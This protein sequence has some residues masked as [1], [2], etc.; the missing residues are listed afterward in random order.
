MHYTYVLESLKKPGAYYRGSC[1]DLVAR[2]KDHNAGRC[3]STEP[4]RPWK[5]RFYAAFDTLDLA[6]ELLIVK[7]L[8][9]YD[10]RSLT[11]T[12]YLILYPILNPA[13]HLKFTLQWK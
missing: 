12:P 3:R 8:L 11:R 13:L 1:A 4:L 10:D 7:K 5:V 2:V 6:R 9:I